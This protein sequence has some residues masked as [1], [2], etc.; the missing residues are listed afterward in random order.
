MHSLD[1]LIFIATSICLNDEH[2]C[3]VTTY[4]TGPRMIACRCSLQV[5]I[6]KSSIDYERGNSDKRRKRQ[7]KYCS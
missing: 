7:H 5:N 2:S 6:L 1:L 3:D 4:L